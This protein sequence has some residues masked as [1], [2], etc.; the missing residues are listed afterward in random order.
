MQSA[1]DWVSEAIEEAAQQGVEEGNWS[2]ET[3]DQ[4]VH[5]WETHDPETFTEA[6]NDLPFEVGSSA[7]GAGEAVYWGAF[8]GAS[9]TVEAVGDTAGNTAG[10][11]AGGLLDGMGATNALLLGGGGLV[12]LWLLLNSE[13][14]GS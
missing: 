6:L 13:E 2:Q 8:S 12:V 10:N 14:V 7:W 9:D 4:L 5:E 11:L 3:A 1:D